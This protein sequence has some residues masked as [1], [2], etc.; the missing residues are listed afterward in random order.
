M[1][2]QRYYELLDALFLYSTHEGGP[3]VVRES[4]A[5]GVPYIGN[6]IGAGDVVQNGH[7]GYLLQSKSLS[8]I[9]KCIQNIRENQDTLRRN[10]RSVI[11][12]KFL[13]TQNIQAI[14]DVYHS[15]LS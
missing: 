11:E 10:C 8:E 5:V 9:E 6:V 15:I 3:L 2:L 14:E 13:L 4:Q 1:P 7:N 12:E